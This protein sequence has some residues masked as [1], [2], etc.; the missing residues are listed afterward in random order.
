MLEPGRNYSVA[1]T[2]YR[3]GFNGKEK[4]D[5][6]NG[7]GVDYDYGARILDVRLG[8]FLSA[9]PLTPKYPELTPYQFASN[10]P[11]V[12]ID[13]DGREIENYEA[14]QIVKNHGI[15]ALNV[16]DY[17]HGHG[18]LV[19]GTYSTQIHGNME[20]FEKLEHAYTT[21]PGILHNPNNKWAQY[22]VLNPEKRTSN[23]GPDKESSV[24][25]IGS[26]KVGD[27]MLIKISA[28]LGIKLDIYVRFTDT[29]YS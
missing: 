28:M 9:D 5:E 18:P 16:I 10:S 27:N 13:L 2:N 8:R 21:D 14:T 6:I 20:S 12:G 3:Y 26:L 4:S 7:S 15:A 17:H 23:W 29:S 22:D 1:N 11:I 24:K 19:K 25:R